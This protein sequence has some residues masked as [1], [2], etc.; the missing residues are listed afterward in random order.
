V[1]KQESEMILRNF[2]FMFI[3]HPNEITEVLLRLLCNKEIEF[4]FLKVLKR[5]PSHW[6]IST[7]A[8]ILLRAVRTS[9]YAQRSSKLELA[10]NRVQNEKLNIKLVKLKRSNVV[11]N[12]YRR[13]KHCLQQFY[14]TSCVVYQ[15]G[16][17]VHV[18]CAKQL[19]RE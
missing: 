7:L 17:Q 5:L 15:D 13:C 2:F 6:T 9:S 3:R 10:L 8:E 11:I 18:H 16:S 14:E 1:Y 19:N 12:E 4:D